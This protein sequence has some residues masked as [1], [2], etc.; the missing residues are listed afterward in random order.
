MNNILV[1]AFDNNTLECS[2]QTVKV[3]DTIYFKAKDV[4]H[5]LGYTHRSQAIHQHVDEEDVKKL[6]DLEHYKGGIKLIPPLNGNDMKT[7]Y[8]NESGFYSLI[9]RS[10]KSEAKQ[11]KRWITNDVLP[12]LR[13]TGSYTINT[14]I[15]DLENENALHR[16][17]V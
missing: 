15:L 8:I 3:D 14:N 16:N 6:E 11:F 10:N 12:S 9:I 2:I 17:V 13:K 7:F 5:A 1:M 4:A